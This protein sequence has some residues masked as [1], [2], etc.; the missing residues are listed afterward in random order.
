[1][2]ANPKNLLDNSPRYLSNSDLEMNPIDA[3]ID[4]TFNKNPS[5]DKQ[6]NIHQYTV[7]E[8]LLGM[9]NAILNVFNDLLKLKFTV[10][11]FTKQ[12]RLFYL[13]LFIIIVVLIIYLFSKDNESNTNQSIINQL[14]NMQQE[15]KEINKNLQMN[16]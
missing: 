11:T 9:K 10:K 13:G 12:N 2:A 8:L 3:Y 1:M 4:N 5:I 7:G 16:K 15:I 6:K 14:Q